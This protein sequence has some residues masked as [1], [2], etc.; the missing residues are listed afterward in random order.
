MIYEYLILYYSIQSHLPLD[1]RVGYVAYN[2]IR[3]FKQTSSCS[4]DVVAIYDRILL[5]QRYNAR[6]N[7]ARISR[8]EKTA[9]VERSNSGRIHLSPSPIPYRDH[10]YGHDQT[11]VCPNSGIEY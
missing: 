7:Y 6:K 8:S 3:Y 9:K 10:N 2:G 11:L 5:L 4:V 1:L